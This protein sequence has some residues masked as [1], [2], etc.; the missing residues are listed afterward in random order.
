MTW[1]AIP[2]RPFQK[3]MGLDEVMCM[4]RDARDGARRSFADCPVADRRPYNGD[5]CLMKRAKGY[6]GLAPAEGV[7]ACGQW[8]GDRNSFTVV[9]P[10]PPPAQPAPRRDPSDPPRAPRSRV[11]VAENQLDTIGEQLFSAFSPNKKPLDRCTQRASQPR[12]LLPLRN[13]DS[14]TFNK[15][16]RQYGATVATS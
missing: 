6:P 13:L 8:H 10:P 16:A 1:P 2:A 7:Q 3:M 14:E 12:V 9:S 5:E 4:T 15:H 11:C